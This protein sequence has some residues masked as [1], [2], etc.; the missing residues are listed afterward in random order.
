MTEASSKKHRQIAGLISGSNVVFIMIF[1][2]F[3]G[4]AS[5]NT[6]VLP[7][8][9]YFFLTLVGYVYLYIH[10]DKDKRFG[11]LMLPITLMII[12]IFSYLTTARF[13]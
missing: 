12:A 6:F 4:L 1:Q 7:F 9:S 5:G 13:N 8:I 2:P 10:S 11:L 3:N